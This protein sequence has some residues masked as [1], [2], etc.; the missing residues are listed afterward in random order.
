MIAEAL[1]LY[2]AERAWRQRGASELARGL[3]RYDLAIR[4]TIGLR[5]QERLPSDV[6]N[7]VAACRSVHRDISL[8]F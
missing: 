4:D 5:L 6:A 1:A 7:S 3:E 2:E 8:H